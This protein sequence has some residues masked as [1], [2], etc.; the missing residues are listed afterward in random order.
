MFQ[1]EMTLNR[2][3]KGTDRH[4]EPVIARAKKATE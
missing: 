2:V 3:G 4:W 1:L